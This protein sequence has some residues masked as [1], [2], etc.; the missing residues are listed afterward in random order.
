MKGR[1]VRTKPRS[2]DP[3]FLIVADHEERAHKILRR[4]KVLQYF[5]YWTYE[6]ESS[7]FRQE[8]P[9]RP[10]RGTKYVKEIEKRWSVSYEINTIAIEYDKK[11]DGMYPLLSNDRELSAAQ[12]FEAHKR[13]PKLE[14]RFE[15]LKS[16]HEIAPVFLKNEGRIEALFFVY[17]LALLVQALIERQMRL[18]MEKEGIEELPLYPE[19]RKSKHPTAELILKLFSHLQCNVL[20]SNGTEFKRFHP[21]LTELQAQVLKLLGVAENGFEMTH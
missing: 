17:F 13:Q 8:R 21:E 12:A 4:H 9:G 2:Q 20:S 16:V 7:Q 1:S 3:A 14:K 11:S 5:R 6:H 19:E 10:G 15:Q 18:A